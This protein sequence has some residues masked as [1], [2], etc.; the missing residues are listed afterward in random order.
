M[1][2][3]TP[4]HRV[5]DQHSLL[6]AEWLRRQPPDNFYLFNPAVICHHG[7]RLMV[8]RVDFGCHQVRRVACASCVLDQDWRVA[9][10]SVVAL[11]DTIVDGGDN[12]Y[13]PRFLIFRDR[14]FVHYNNNWDSVPNQIFLVELD[15]DN[16]Q[17]R[18]AARRL[19]L[20]G[21][22]Q[23]IEKNWLLFDHDG[24]LF[25]IY[26][27]APHIVLRLELGNCGPILCQPGYTS[28]WDTTIYAKRYGPPRGGTPPVRAGERYVSIFHSR[29]QPPPLTPAAL[30]STV[31]T[32]ERVQGWKILKRWLRGQLNPL[33]Y[34]GGAYTFAAT[35]PFAPVFIHSQPVLR[36]EQE[37][38]QRR[39]TASHLAPRRVVFPSGLVHL[40]DDRWLV[41]YGAH[42]ER[43][44]LRTLSQNE[45]VGGND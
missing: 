36:P 15:A 2:T 30:S 12:H 41:S 18:S 4:Q 39:P 10:G 14:L 13:D 28:E 35:P 8:Y 34:Y 25:A 38:R 45:L 11:S 21:P 33:K 3:S 23:K 43:C 42:D 6:P 1:T 22:R 32:L 19:L 9:P 26:Q 17:A 7:R 29:I 5:I 20:E 31:R 16:L 24:D 37:S 44:V 40:N 27:I